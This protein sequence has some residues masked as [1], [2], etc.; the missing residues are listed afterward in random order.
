M[1]GWMP[2]MEPFAPVRPIRMSGLARK[3]MGQFSATIPWMRSLNF[4]PHAQP[5]EVGCCGSAGMRGVLFS[6][7]VP[8]ALLFYLVRAGALL[9][10]TRETQVSEKER[11][12]CQS[13]QI[14]P[15]VGD[16]N[17]VL[18]KGSEEISPA[19]HWFGNAEAEKRERHF[20]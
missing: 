12:Y 7:W 10:C 13:G 8:A 9:Q 5:G 4:L 6:Q 14:H 2:A 11:H 18:L 15:P 17:V 1:A 20:G 16:K 3:L 19:G